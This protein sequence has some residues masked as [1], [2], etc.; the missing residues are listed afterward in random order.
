MRI[1]PTELSGVFIITPRLHEDARGIFV[2]TWNNAEMRRAGIETEFVQ[3]NLSVSTR[4][5]TLRGLHFQA[6]PYE[7]AKLIRCARG[8]VFDVVVDI[9][10][11][12]PTFGEWTGVELSKENGRQV[13]VPP[14]FAHGFC[15]LVDETEVVYKCSD[16]YAPACEGAIAWDDPGL[17]IDWAGLNGDPILSEKDRSAPRLNQIESPF[18]FGANIQ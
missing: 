1:E 18:V 2:E 11:G 16:H 14:G 5:G 6:P 9:R 13:Y 10:R 4:A 7:Q 17:G 8:A 12:S 15:S 3:D